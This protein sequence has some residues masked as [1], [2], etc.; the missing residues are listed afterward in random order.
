MDATI[1]KYVL[2]GLGGYQ[3]VKM[4]RYQA[5]KMPRRARILSVQMQGISDGY[6]RIT[7]W[8]LVEPD[9]PMVAR[10][11][12][13]I[14]TGWEQDFAG[15]MYLATLQDGDLVWHVFDGGEVA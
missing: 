9:A 2:D 15:L 12:V 5:V 13:V 6:R 8:A 3:A 10:R 11:L 7:L 14:G 1:H 4:P